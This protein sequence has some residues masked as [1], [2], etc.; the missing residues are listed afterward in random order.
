MNEDFPAA[1][2]RSA[3]AAA[4]RAGH[5]SEA[6][7]LARQVLAQQ[8]GNAQAWVILGRAAR[9]LREDEEALT[10]FH[11]AAKLAPELA[12]PAFLLCA[13][14]LKTA[15]PEAQTLLG[16]ILSKFPDKAAGWTEIGQVLME[17]G[18][19][20]AA[21]ICYTRA[22]QA[23]PSFQLKLQCGLILKQLGRFSEAVGAFKEALSF[24]ATSA[25]VWF[26]L[27]VCHQNLHNVIEAE[28]AYRTAHSLDPC[29]AEAFVNLGTLLQDQGDLEAAKK[30][31]GDALRSR[32]DTFGRITQA[33]TAA[34]KGELWLDLGKLRL[35]LTA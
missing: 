26:L 18:K 34:P 28:N 33:L 15:N 14:L 32:A 4:L 23:S 17:T 30:A 24:D 8:P 3:A 25:R 19:H 21:L 10:A 9:L 5:P 29:L 16:Q 22:A 1:M 27:G 11:K 20:E 2:E 12:E 31:Y 13:M 35:S 6:K 7:R